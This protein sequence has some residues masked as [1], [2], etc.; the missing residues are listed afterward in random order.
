M[1]S[2]TMDGLQNL[3]SKL[4]P[5]GYAIID[6]YSGVATCKQAVDDFRADRKITEQLERVDW[7]GVYWKKQA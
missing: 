5:G 4:S 1:Y 2:S 6:D 7:T 3:Y